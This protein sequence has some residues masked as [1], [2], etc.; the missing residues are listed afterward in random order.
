MSSATGDPAARS[1]KP[2]AAVEEEYDD[3]PAVTKTAPAPKAEESKPANAGGS[4][5]EDILAMIRNRK[6]Q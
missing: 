6:Q 3:E 4:K 2:T 1:S 5:A